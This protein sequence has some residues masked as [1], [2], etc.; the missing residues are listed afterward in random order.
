MPPYRLADEPQPGTMARL[1]VRPL[2]PL[3]GVMFAGPWLSWPWF[4]FN[5]FAVGSPTRTRELRMAAVGLVGSAVLVAALS[6]LFSRQVI[7]G[8][9]LRYL[10]TVV[11]LWQLAITYSL[12]TLQARTFG[13]YEYYGGAVQNGL[14]VLFVAF[15][16]DG[17]LGPALMAS[18]GR[19]GSLARL[20]LGF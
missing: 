14:P 12:Y 15:I 10:M 19:F 18:L 17:R 11:I 13:I 7:D 1:A 6:M 9:S 8:G 20:V 5:A 16:I 4:V 3:L 2:W